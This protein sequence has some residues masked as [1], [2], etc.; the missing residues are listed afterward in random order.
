MQIGN[1]VGAE[2]HRSFILF[3]ISAVMSTVYVSIISA[4]AAT[5]IWPPLKFRHPSF[6][7]EFARNDLVFGTLKEIFLA[8]LRS[9]LFLSP[10]GLF[11]VYLFIASVLV[12]IGLCVLL[13]Q[14]LCFIYEGKTY[15]SHLSSQGAEDENDGIGER[16][17]QNLIR[18]FN[19]PSSALR[20]LPSLWNLRKSHDK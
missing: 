13:W 15:L 14:Q 2:N 4:Y 6:L 10:R 8:L 16:D 7:N 17:L 3:L 9:A 5:Q 18:F 19:F 11:I 1:C 12:E 20:F